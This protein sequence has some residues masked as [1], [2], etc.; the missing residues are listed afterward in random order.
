MIGY[1]ILI[2][3]AILTAFVTS[4]LQHIHL[5]HEIKQSIK[6]RALKELAFPTGLDDS[7][8]ATK[9]LKFYKITDY[10]CDCKTLSTFFNAALTG[11]EVYYGIETAASCKCNYNPSY[12]V[13]DSIIEAFKV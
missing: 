13:K 1:S 9:I 2:S 8:Y 6:S 10:N 12:D 5:T 7:F 3:L 11:Y 4:Q